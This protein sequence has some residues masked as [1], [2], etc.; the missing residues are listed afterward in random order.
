MM[1]SHPSDRHVYFARLGGLGRVRTV[2]I[3]GAFLAALSAVTAVHADQVDDTH[4]AWAFFNRAT[5]FLT[6]GD[7][8]NAL[9]NLNKAIQLDPNYADAYYDRGVVYFGQHEYDKALAD[10]DK[11]LQL[12]AQSPN[13]IV[14]LICG[15]RR[16]LFGEAAT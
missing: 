5:S 7:L 13:L 15:P 16:R 9:I 12:S 6:A 1:W 11:A 8:D 10:Y 14:P 2:A 3:A 4:P